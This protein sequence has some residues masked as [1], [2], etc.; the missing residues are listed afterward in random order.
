LSAGTIRAA[1]P[2]RLRLR[3]SRRAVTKC[4]LALIVLAGVGAGGWFWFRGSSLVAVNHVEISGVRGAQG[5][6][7]EQALRSAAENMTTLEF[8]VTQ[9]QALDRTY[10]EIVS[11]TATTHFPHRVSIHVVERL[12]IGVVAVGGQELTVARD[13]ALLGDAGIRARSLPV[14]ETATPPSGSRLESADG[15]PEAEVL[16]AAP[17]RLRGEIEKVSSNATDGV[18]ISFRAGPSVYFGSASEVAAKWAAAIA[19]L[20]NP[21]S[22]GACYIDVS[23][24]LRPAAG[25]SDVTCGGSVTGGASAT[26]T[27]AGTGGTAATSGTQAAS[28]ASTGGSAATPGTQAPSDAS[29]GVPTGGVGTA[30]SPAGATSSP[31]STAPAGSASTTP[32]TTGG[33]SVGG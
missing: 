10:P 28:G 25:A 30:T 11:V 26:Q 4:V 23:V 20:A 7:I 32:A 12:P 6:E 9:L 14:I 16:G 21:R 22:A 29:T 17:A 31:G 2:R 13:G 24:P 3:I 33:A 8:N 5:A 18:V 27:P 1:R 19:V 15:L